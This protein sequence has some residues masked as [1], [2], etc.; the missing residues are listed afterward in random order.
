LIHLEKKGLVMPPKAKRVVPSTVKKKTT[1]AKASSSDEWEL[2]GPE[3][4]VQPSS[5]FFDYYTVLH[6]TAGVGKSSLM[7][8]IPGSMIFQFEPARRN[9][10]ARQVNFRIA[11]VPEL[12]RGV[13]NAW[14]KFT[15]LLE[16]AE[17][18][19]TI[20]VIGIDNISECYKACENNWLLENNM[21]SVPSKDYG[22]SRSQITREFE[23]VLNSLKFNSR[24]GVIFTAHTKEREGELNTGTTET[25]YSPACP[26]AVFEWLKKAMDFA[27]FVGYHDNKRAVHCRWDT[28]WTKCGVRDRFCNT[29]GKPLNG[30]FLPTDPTKGYETLVKAWDNKIKSGIFQESEE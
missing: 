30:F 10:V 15:T 26:G 11:T 22:A 28:I 17:S 16:K 9:I 8:S 25:M 3:D 29:A 21:E 19:S 7:A 20:K 6:G 23:R 12:E 5:N 13:E 4:L 27:F 18:D 14:V 24:L 1:T 2:P